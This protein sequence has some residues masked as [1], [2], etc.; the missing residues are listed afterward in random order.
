MR[1]LLFGSCLFFPI[2]ELP[3]ICSKIMAARQSQRPELEKTKN[4]VNFI[5]STTG[6]FFTSDVIVK[7]PINFQPQAIFLG[8]TTYIVQAP[9]ATCFVVVIVAK[10]FG[11]FWFFLGLLGLF[12]TK[13]I[14]VKHQPAA[15]PSSHLSAYLVGNVIPKPN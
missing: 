4:L 3:E 15:A 7:C 8:A 11:T 6:G 5:S 1:S 14:H 2:L 9:L 10:S 13:Y 12:G